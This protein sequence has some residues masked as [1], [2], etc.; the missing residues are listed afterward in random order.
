MLS[1]SVS[2]RSCQFLSAG[3]FTLHQS[4][5][6]NI[7]SLFPTLS[8]TSYCPWRPKL[9]G[10][11]FLVKTVSDISPELNLAMPNGLCF[12]YHF[13]TDP[14]FLSL[15]KEGKV[16]EE[17]QGCFWL[18]QKKNFLFCVFHLLKDRR[19]NEESPLV[20]LA[21]S[22]RMVPVDSTSLYTLMP[23]A[24]HLSAAWHPPAPWC[25][26]MAIPSLLH[27]TWDC[28]PTHTQ[29]PLT[30][31]CHTTLTPLR[32]LLGISELMLHWSVPI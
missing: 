29:I 10:W 8:I 14:S 11:V 28:S 32:L 1:L 23:A 22:P 24:M 19:R 3:H 9:R 7:P 17:V 5:H 12:L 27:T 16:D 2:L 25:A 4:P 18:A 15:S 20:P 30:Q 13:H 31:P 21:P 26:G 6:Q